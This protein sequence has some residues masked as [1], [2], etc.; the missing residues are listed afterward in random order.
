MAYGCAVIVSCGRYCGIAEL[1]ANGEAL[2]L[3]DP[4]DPAEL[5]QALESLMDPAARKT[6]SERARQCV[7]NASWDRTAATVLAALEKSARERGRL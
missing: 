1:A 3:R 4:R 5:A 7:R 2:L 6:L